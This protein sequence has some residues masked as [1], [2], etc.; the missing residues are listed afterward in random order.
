MFTL[1]PKATFRLLL[2]LMFLSLSA[3]ADNSSSQSASEPK[4]SVKSESAK[5]AT[6]AES[7]PVIAVR[8]PIENVDPAKFLSKIKLP[9]GFKV[10][11]YAA[12]VEGA[13][14]MALGSNG[15]V[16]VG[17]RGKRGDPENRGSVYAVVDA[18]GDY[19]AD[20]VTVLDD[21]LFMPNGVAF[22]NG[23]LYVAEPNRIL[24]YDNIEAELPT[25]PAPVVV[26][27]S[28]PSDT[29]HGWKYIK[30]G[31]DERLYVPVGAPC[32]IC[33]SSDDYAVINSIK[34]DGSDKQIVAKGIR[35][36]VGFDWHPQTK[37]LWFTDNGRD[38]WGDDQ[39]PEELNRVSQQGQ[40][41]GYPYRYGK[42]LIDPEFAAPEQE[43]I[44]AEVELPAHTAPLGM[45]FYTGKM[46]PKAYQN[47]ILIAHHGSW[48]RSV[49]DGYYLSLV[50]L[51]DGKA[52]PHKVFAS[53]WLQEGRSWGRPVDLLQLPDGS[54]LVSD[55]EAS[56]IYRISYSAPS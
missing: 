41:F 40:H 19:L 4:Q 55:D 20:T 25:L 12:S 9:D 17:T 11:L 52:Q 27:D 7:E 50:T 28:F 38:L 16:F 3:C 24:R 32:N 47:Q 21:D 29:H 1:K 39:P 2:V 43:L 45:M 15:T 49:P 34:A 8:N 5:D 30:F 42:Q 23:S 51:E 46:F 36:T 18:D 48:N 22:K 53:G 44:A 37:E 6:K 13:R 26:N 33:E 56:C 31:P 10:E 54:V 35:N 14:S